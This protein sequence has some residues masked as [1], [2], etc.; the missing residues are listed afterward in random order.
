MRDRV[1]GGRCG[2]LIPAAEYAAA[3]DG[4]GVL[5]DEACSILCQNQIFPEPLEVTGCTDDGPD[6]NGDQLLACER[7][8]GP[9]VRAARQ[10]GAMARSLADC[11]IEN[12]VEGCVNETYAALE[13]GWQARTMPAFGHIAWDEARHA[14][15]AWDI[16]AWA[17]G[18]VDG[19]ARAQVAAARSLALKRLEQSCNRPVPASL[20]ATLGLPTS[21]QAK[22]LAAGLRAGLEAG[23]VTA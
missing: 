15:L 13:A 7:N 17:M 20:V 8:E 21:A 12:M 4:N 14:T 11:A 10:M 2:L 1:H 19:R 5:T 16:H 3:L 23:S 6:A 22:Q 9:S 18:E